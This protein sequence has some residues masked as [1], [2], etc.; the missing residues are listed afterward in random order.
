MGVGKES[1]TCKEWY[2]NTQKPLK[3]FTSLKKKNQGALRLH[4]NKKII[5]ILKVC[6]Y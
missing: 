6:F 3:M 1:V 5:S 4:T 2:L